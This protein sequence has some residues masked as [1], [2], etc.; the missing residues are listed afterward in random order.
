M[1]TTNKRLV[2]AGAMASTITST[3]QQLANVITFS[4]QAVFTGSPVGTFKLQC[5]TDTATDGTPTLVQPT[6]WDDIPNSSYAITAAGSNT[7]N[8]SGNTGFSWVRLV[9]TASS[10][11]GV[12]NV[13]INTKGY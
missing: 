1:L 6:N 9:Y 2:T 12:L 4:I 13:K 11:S 10:G 7:W 8:Y 5:S 3:A